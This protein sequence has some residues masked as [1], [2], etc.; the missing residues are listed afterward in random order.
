[1]VR[2]LN[3]RGLVVLAHDWRGQGLS[4]RMLPDRLRG[5]A[6]GLQAYL[7]DYAALLDAF[8]ER[9]P[10]PWI[11]FAHSMGACLQLLALVKG[12][13][14]LEAAF[15]SAPMLAVQ[16]GPWPLG[17][18]RGIVAATGLIGLAGASA[19]PVSDPLADAFVMDRLTHDRTRYERYK[20]QLRAC[21]DLAIGAITWGWLGFALKAGATVAAPGAMES[22]AVPVAMV[23]AG[24][25]RLVLNG[26]A[27]IAARRL[28]KG[29]YGEIAG[30]YHELLMETDEVRSEIWAVFDRLIAPFISPRG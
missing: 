7:G 24:E 18:T 6:Q 5:H 21:P 9:L 25:D 14:R 15:L 12:E 16:T 10:K 17:F 26:A 3:Q 11:G 2:E 28:P 13:R 20:A 30:A 23:A 29:S 8:S 27:R 1:V 19:L 22:V 4:E